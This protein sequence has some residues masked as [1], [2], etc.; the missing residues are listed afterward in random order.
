MHHR[1]AADL[2]LAARLHAD[3]ARAIAAGDQNA[4]AAASDRLLDYIQ[5]FTRKTID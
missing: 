1:Q 5:T 2:P 3:I 4:A